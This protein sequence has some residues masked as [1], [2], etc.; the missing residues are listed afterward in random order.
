MNRFTGLFYWGCFTGAVLLGRLSQGFGFWGRPLMTVFL[1][2]ENSRQGELREWKT[3][4][5]G[6]R[7]NSSFPTFLSSCL[8]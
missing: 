8:S 5:P 3:Q 2:G 7:K 1:C 4:L 6:K